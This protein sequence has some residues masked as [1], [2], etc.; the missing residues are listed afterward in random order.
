MSGGVRLYEETL[1]NR[2]VRAIAMQ[3]LAGGALP[4]KEAIEYVCGLPNVESI[5]FGAS[6]RQNIA[7]TAEYIRAFDEAAVAYTQR[8]AS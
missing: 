1:R 6:S 7:Q 2:K 4:P 5:L 8:I 3:V